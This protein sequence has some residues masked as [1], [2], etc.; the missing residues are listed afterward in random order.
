MYWVENAGWFSAESRPTLDRLMFLAN[1]VV[2]SLAVCVSN[3]A[4]LVFH[5]RIEDL[6]GL[7]LS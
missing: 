3:E 4:A 7:G 5:Q 1:A 6:N 2:F